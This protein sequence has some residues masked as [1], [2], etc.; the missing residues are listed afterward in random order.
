MLGRKLTPSGSSR[1]L[2]SRRTLDKFGGEPVSDLQ[3]VLDFGEQRLGVQL[4]DH[5]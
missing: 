4:D 1:M 5:Y 2:E 3:K